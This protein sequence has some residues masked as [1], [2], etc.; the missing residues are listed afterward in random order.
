MLIALIVP[1]LLACAVPVVADS[2]EQ[3]PHVTMIDGLRVL[4]GW[5]AATPAG[6]DALIYLEI[7]NATATAT[8]LTGARTMGAELE[9]VGWGYSG[10]GETLAVLTH[11]SVPPGRSIQLEPK[12]LALQWANV[13]TDLVEGTDLELEI[14]LGGHRFKTRVE[15]G[16][17]DAT[18]HSHAGHAH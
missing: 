6:S 2:Q 13:P 8:A 1:A 14:D 12:G 7:E 4:H 17:S 5:S 15:I 3:S 9:L 18:A 10:A 11:I 16:A